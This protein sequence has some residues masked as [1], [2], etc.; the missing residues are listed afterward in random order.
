MSHENMLEKMLIEI[1]L[2]G[3]D[4]AQ[5][6][7]Y[8]AQFNIAKENPAIPIP[9]PVCFLKGET[10]RLNPLQDENGVSIVRCTRCREYFSFRSEEIDRGLNNSK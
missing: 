9:C 7:A 1:R 10:Q 5:V 4:E 8:L 3:A 2:K 6:N